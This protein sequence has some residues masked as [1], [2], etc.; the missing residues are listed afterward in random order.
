MARAATGAGDGMVRVWDPLV[1]VFHWTL[2]ASFIGAFVIER[3][4]DLHEALGC[5]ALGAVAIRLVWGVIGTR[6]ARFSDF[7]AGPGRL[8]G[9]LADILRGRERRYL[10]HNPAGG[11]MVL[12][13]MGM[14]IVIGV[15]GW[16]M[17][18]DAWFGEAWVEDLHEGAVNVTLGLVALHLSGVVWGSVRHGENLVRAMITGNKRR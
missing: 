8:L 9:Y 5:V 18:T 16:M 11:A 2:A 6:H 10:G 1:R 17:G 13:L 7:V 15:S 4:R 3:P 14:V 12:A